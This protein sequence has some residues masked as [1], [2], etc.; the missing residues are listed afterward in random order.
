MSPVVPISL[1]MGYLLCSVGTWGPMI[2]ETIQTTKTRKAKIPHHLMIHLV[3]LLP[4]GLLVVF[5]TEN[6]PLSLGSSPPSSSPAAPKPV[7]AQPLM[8]GERERWR[9]HL[10]ECARETERE[11]ERERR[12]RD[13]YV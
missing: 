6:A 2:S 7:P 12:E 5:I 3:S 1:W 8:T 13:V 9:I 11:R 10:G 4:N